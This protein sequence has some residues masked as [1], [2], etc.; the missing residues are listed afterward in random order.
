MDTEHLPEINNQPV[1]SFEHVFLLFQGVE[2]SREHSQFY[3]F[4][5]SVWPSRGNAALWLFGWIF[6][7]YFWLKQW[8]FRI[9]PTTSDSLLAAGSLQPAESG[10]LRAGQKLM[11]RHVAL[12]TRPADR[13]PIFREVQSC[14]SAARRELTAKG[15]DQKCME[16]LHGWSKGGVPEASWGTFT[17]IVP[18]PLKNSTKRLPRL[19]L[20]AVSRGSSN[21]ANAY[22]GSSP[23]SS[24]FFSFL[25]S[26]GASHFF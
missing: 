3:F 20:A 19:G 18:A 25:Q 17:S 10:I 14:L 7:L 26:S 23:P 8:I 15:L 5:P 4:C 16:S 11:W 2:V 21:K 22:E 13:M 12:R 9:G 24:V 6:A 1:P